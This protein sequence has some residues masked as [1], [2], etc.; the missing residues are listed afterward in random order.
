MS[1]A[2]SLRSLL[3]SALL[4]ASPRVA[5]AGRPRRVLVLGYGAVGDTIF[6]LPFLEALKRELEP[7]RL[8]FLAN[9]SPVTRELIPATGLADEVVL[10]ECDGGDRAGINRWIKGQGFDLAVLS[11]PAPADYFQAGLA[12][13]PARAGHCRVLPGRAG[14]WRKFR[15]ALIVGEYAR[16]ALLN[17]AAW[18]REGSEPA[19]ARNLR[20]L[21]ALGLP[22]RPASERPRLPLGPAHRA[23]AARELGPKTRRRVG[24]HLG[25]PVN[26]YHKIWDGGRFGELLA[27]LSALEPL[28]MFCVGGPG[29]EEALAAARRGVADLRSWAGKASLLESFALI[30]TCDLFLS[31]DTGLA[32][33]AAALGVPTVTIWGPSDIV[34]VGHQWELEKHLDVRTGI[35]CS[36]CARLGMAVEGALNYRTCGHHACLA[37][38]SADFAFS[39]VKAKLGR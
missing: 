25:P 38:L 8:V 5:P 31:C 10:H 33:A 13:I 35:S 7:E 3:H 11:L 27:K 22:P 32:K 29:E 9:A 30:E 6:F 17:R 18:I 15:H 28:D 23:F 20:L 37:E 12:S 24:V 16:R 14:A 21:T 19:S 26:Q 36:P 34:E 4:W 39:A 2:A 1:K